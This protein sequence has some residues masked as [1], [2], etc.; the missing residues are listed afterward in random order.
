MNEIDSELKIH[1]NKNQDDEAS[2]FDSS[3]KY[4]SGDDDMTKF[5][6]KPV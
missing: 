3:D 5:I 4:S 2:V 6:A 1:E